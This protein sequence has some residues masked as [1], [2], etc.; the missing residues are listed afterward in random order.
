[1]TRAEARLAELLWQH[2]PVASGQMIKLATAQFGWKKST[3]FSILKFLIN[4]GL[5][6]NQESLVSMLYSREEFDAHQSIEYVDDAFDG[7]LPSFV[8]A[9]TSSRRLTPEQAEQIRQLIDESQGKPGD[10][11][12]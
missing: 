9:F 6:Q 7:S 11:D 2:A 5:A 1:M 12:D 8:A 4:K 10:D 3:T